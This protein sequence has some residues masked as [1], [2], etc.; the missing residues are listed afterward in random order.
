MESAAALVRALPL[1]GDACSYLK[2]LA[3]VGCFCRQLPYDTMWVK[4]A[5]AEWR[6]RAEPNAVR[7]GGYQVMLGEAAEGC[8]AEPT[9]RMTHAD[10]LRPA[11]RSTSW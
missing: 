3:D 2:A 1:E 7:E 9:D 11:R 8:T 10:L 5:R 4:T 6:T